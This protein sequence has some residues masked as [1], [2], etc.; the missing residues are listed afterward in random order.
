MEV[1]RSLRRL[2]QHGAEPSHKAAVW[3]STPCSALN[4][5]LK[6]RRRDAFQDKSKNQTL[7]PFPLPSSLFKLIISQVSLTKGPLGRASFL[8]NEMGVF[9]PR[10]SQ[11]VRRTKSPALCLEH[12]TLGHGYLDSTPEM[13]W[14]PAGASAVGTASC[15]PASLQSPA[16]VEPQAPR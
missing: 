2:E 15:T 13:R 5:T 14:K 3:P 16:R 4:P 12:K 1:C 9:T 6:A 10:H 8:S 7:L 11:R